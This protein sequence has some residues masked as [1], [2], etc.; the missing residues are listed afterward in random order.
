M[1]AEAECAVI[2]G[3]HAFKLLKEMAILITDQLA[4]LLYV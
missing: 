4:Y 2:E 3:I 1:L